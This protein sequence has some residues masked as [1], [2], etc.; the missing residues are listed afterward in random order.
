MRIH[1][2]REVLD[3]PKGF[4]CAS[5]CLSVPPR[6]QRSEVRSEI[7]GAQR[8]PVVKRLDSLFSPPS[9]LSSSLPF[10]RGRRSTLH[11]RTGT[12]GAQWRG[13]KVRGPKRV[14]L[15][16]T[17]SV[18][19]LRLP[20]LA[21]PRDSPCVRGRRVWSPSASP[22]RLDTSTTVPLPSSGNLVMLLYSSEP[23]NASGGSLPH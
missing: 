2:G 1:R 14:A 8:P 4:Q 18:A 11:S 16:V 10:D 12:G 22:G 3:F 20:R 17:A 23:Q 5:H 9:F 21:Y 7:P 6:R 15:L 19:S 13:G